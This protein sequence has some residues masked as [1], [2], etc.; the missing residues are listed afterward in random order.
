MVAVQ[1]DMNIIV[2][3]EICFICYPICFTYFGDNLVVY[4]LWLVCFNN[5]Y[6]L[7][8]GLNNY[9]QEDYEYFIDLLNY[10]IHLLGYLSP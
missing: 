8:V 3:F 6:F 1:T 5:C 2:L 7:E 10:R 4:S 9:K